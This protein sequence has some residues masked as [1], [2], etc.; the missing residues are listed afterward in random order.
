M[1]GGS[2]AVGKPS[3]PLRTWGAAAPARSPGPA[4]M[5]APQ[6]GR[7]DP[8]AG[9]FVSG[10]VGAAAGPF[11]PPLP[12]ALP[13]PLRRIRLPRRPSRRGDEG[14]RRRQA[15]GCGLVPRAG[16]T[17]PSLGRAF[18]SVR[19]AARGPGRRAGRAP[20]LAAAPVSLGREQNPG[21]SPPSPPGAAPR[22]RAT[23]GPPGPGRSPGTLLCPIRT[24]T[25]DT[26]CALAMR[27]TC[28]VPRSPGWDGE[29]LLRARVT[30]PHLLWW[31]ISIG[32]PVPAPCPP[33][34]QL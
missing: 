27:C 8:R 16:G 29:M 30:L 7:R 10:G 25:L 34:P 11:V 4:G 12:P 5:E 2:A 6:R 15:R 18:C 3:G 17:S 14:Q 24:R 13:E 9:S 23:C 20:A 28:P 22:P 33:G 32:G 19:W 31:E 26:A 1:A 21:G